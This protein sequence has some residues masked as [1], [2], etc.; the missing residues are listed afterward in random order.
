ME[1]E[2]EIETLRAKEEPKEIKALSELTGLSE[3]EV[4]KWLETIPTIEYLFPC[5][6]CIIAIR[7]IVKLKACIACIRK[8]RER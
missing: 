4:K 6:R 2:A 7:P 3:K 1:L 5:L 8:L